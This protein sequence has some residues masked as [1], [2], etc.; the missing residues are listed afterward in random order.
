MIENDIIFFMCGMETNIAADNKAH[1]KD[2]L[3]VMLQWILTVP[4]P[5]KYLINID[6][7]VTKWKMHYTTV[8][9][10][11]TNHYLT[12]F[13]HP[14]LISLTTLSTVMLLHYF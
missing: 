12:E 5:V 6:A 7:P 11:A 9:S 4:A 3:H 2:V 8:N 13:S 14:K 10:T 1:F